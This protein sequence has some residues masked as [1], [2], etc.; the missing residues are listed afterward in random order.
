MS[1]TN[2]LFATGTIEKLNK[3]IKVSTH[4][5]YLRS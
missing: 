4:V 2:D 1:I 5:S 3:Y